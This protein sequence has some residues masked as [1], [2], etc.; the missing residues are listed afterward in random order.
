MFAAGL[1]AAPLA[2]AE[3]CI[4]GFVS[5][6]GT[7]GAVVVE[8]EGDIAAG[9]VADIPGW[10]LAVCSGIVCAGAAAS[11]LQP[12]VSHAQTHTTAMRLRF[13]MV[14]PWLLTKHTFDRWRH[15]HVAPVSCSSFEDVHR[16][17]LAR[18]DKNF[19]PP[20]IRFDLTSYTVFLFAAGLSPICL[21]FVGSPICAST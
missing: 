16:F 10:G 19:H 12:H 13:V 8:V 17:R 15:L 9:V 1:P 21:S 6:T 4:I 5:V 7:A 3:G 18:A 2:G 11:P 20:R 14:D